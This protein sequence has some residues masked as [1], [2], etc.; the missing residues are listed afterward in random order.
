MRIVVRPDSPVPIYE[1]IVSQVVFAIAAGDI[2]VGEDIPSVR[3]LA[4]Q[5]VVNPNTVA[6]AYQELERLG[7]LESR[8]GLN[9]VVSAD[10]PRLCRDRRK[11]IVRGRV[12][13]ALREAAAAGLDADDVHQI[14]DAEWPQ[15][16]AGRNGQAEPTRS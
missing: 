13:E 8:R 9:M 4:H 15:L 14:V 10:G 16:A 5:L 11:E 1:Q 6:R 2:R 3:E 7:V 12:R